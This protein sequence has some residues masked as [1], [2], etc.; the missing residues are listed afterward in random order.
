MCNCSV[1]FRHFKY[2]SWCR[3]RLYLSWYAPLKHQS[4]LQLRF[5]VAL[6]PLFINRRH[7]KYVSWCH[8]AFIFTILSLQVRFC[9]A[10][11][12]R[13]VPTQLYKTHSSD[14]RLSIS[15]LSALPTTPL[16]LLP[17]GLQQTRSSS[18]VSGGR[19]TSP[20]PTM[21]GRRTS[22]ENPSS[23]GM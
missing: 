8:H 4:S 2:V 14:C 23:L 16:L 20:R 18:S 7:F 5:A 6:T 15:G 13:H 1:W 9:N 10:A 21:A 19:E 12:A 11:D 17:C 3:L 22:P